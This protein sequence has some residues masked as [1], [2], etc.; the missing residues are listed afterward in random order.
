MKKI[1]LKSFSYRIHS[2]DP[3]EIMSP[4]ESDAILTKEEKELPGQSTKEE[5]KNGVDK[6]LQTTLQK[7]RS[8]QSHA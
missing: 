7:E 4:L 2:K 6:R 1:D 5:P 8:N 3:D